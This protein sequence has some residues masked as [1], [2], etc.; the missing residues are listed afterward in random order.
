MVNLYMKSVDL[1]LDLSIAQLHL[2]SVLVVGPAASSNSASHRLPLG[3]AFFAKTHI[4]TYINKS[5]LLRV[6]E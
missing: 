2:G 5:R 6:L 4:Y 3:W 1:A